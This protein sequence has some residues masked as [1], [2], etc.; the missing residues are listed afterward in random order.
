[1][2]HAYEEMLD[3]D[4]KLSHIQQT[5][6]EAEQEINQNSDNFIYRLKVA[7]N[8]ALAVVVSDDEQRIGTVYYYTITDR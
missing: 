4:V 8:K 2:A 6:A 1:V 7:K 5:L 3:G